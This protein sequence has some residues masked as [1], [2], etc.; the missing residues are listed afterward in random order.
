MKKSNRGLRKRSSYKSDSGIKGK[1]FAEGKNVD[2]KV[3]A[4]DLKSVDRYLVDAA[5]YITITKVTKE[6]PIPVIN[7]IAF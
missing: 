1:S 5:A 6:Y 7:G 2:A 3:D 4:V